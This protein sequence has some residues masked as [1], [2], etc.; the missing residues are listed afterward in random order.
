MPS[1]FPFVVTDLFAP[2]HAELLALLRT[3]PAERWDAPT[4][5]PR[6]RVRDVVAHLLDIDLRELTVR[7]D[8]AWGA[9]PERPLESWAQ[10]L[11]YLD[12][13]NADWVRA[14]R[15][16]GPRVLVELHEVIGPRVAALYESLDLAAPAPFAV[17]W[18]GETTSPNWFELG[19]QYT[20]R[21]HHQQQ[22]REA[23]GAPG[24]TSRRWLRPVLDV[25]MY[26]LPYAYRD[27]PAAPGTTV[28]VVV[29]G[30]AGGAW[31]LARG[32]DAWTL[33][34]CAP[35]DVV[36]PAATIALDQDTAWRLFFKQLTPELAARKVT[37]EG[38]RT[39][40]ERYLS[41][42]AVMA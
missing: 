1:D 7:R 20:E 33:D 3:L 40:G 5:A 38:D 22:I 24:L 16:L 41:V 42:L 15:R 32:R 6:W 14:M 2:L 11:A 21:W 36:A 31:L 9:P 30:D 35:A 28:S 19:R 27:V 8:D 4:A 12:G 13:L 23:V 37:I 17:A 39:L 29:G 34:A 25:S 10:L 26:A 18:A